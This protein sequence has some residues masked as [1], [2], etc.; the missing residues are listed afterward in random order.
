MYVA[1]LN[2]AQQAEVRRRLEQAG[3]E[4]ADIER[5]MDSKLVDLEDTIDIGGLN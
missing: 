2:D 1:Q 3:L 5:G 4:Q